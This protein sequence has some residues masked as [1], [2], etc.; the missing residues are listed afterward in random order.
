M[1]TSK[2]EYLNYLESDRKALRRNASSPPFFNVFDPIW[3]F[4]CLLRKLEFYYNCRKSY[5]FLPYRKFLRYQFIKMQNMLGFQIPI[6]VIG[7]GLYITHI[8]SIVIHDNVRIGKNL[9]INVDVVIGQK[10]SETDVPEIG[11]NVI[12]EPGSKIFGKIKIADG[13]HIGANAV[14]NRSFTRPYSVIAGVPAKEIG[15]VRNLSRHNS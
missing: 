14:V 7:P 10:G 11:N 6:N 8:G 9:R 1:I 12:I 15:V 4:Q 5:Y 3:K 2:N 13:V